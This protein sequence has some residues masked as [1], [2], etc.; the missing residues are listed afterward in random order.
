MEFIIECHTGDAE[1][2]KIIISNKITA[3]KYHLSVRDT[4]NGIPKEVLPKIFD[5]FFSNRSGGTGLGLAVVDQII[6]AHNGKIDVQSEVGKGTEF[7][8]IIPIT[9]GME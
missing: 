3:E 4:G 5:P 6:R 2:G 7:I 1:W 8:V 9:K